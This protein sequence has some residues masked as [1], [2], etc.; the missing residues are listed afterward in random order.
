MLR[1]GELIAVLKWGGIALAT[2]SYIL[3]IIIDVVVSYEMRTSPIVT[4]SV[5][6]LIGMV[7][8]IAGIKLDRRD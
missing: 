6:M 3:V 7:S 1:P 4:F 5:F 8:V 2:V